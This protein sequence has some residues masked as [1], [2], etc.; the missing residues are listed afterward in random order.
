MRVSI[1]ML[2]DSTLLSKQLPPSTTFAEIAALVEADTGQPV[3]KIIFN[4]KL[5]DPL[6]TLATAGY[7]PVRSLVC[8]AL[9]INAQPPARGG[10]SPRVAPINIHEHVGGGGGDLEPVHSNLEEYAPVSGGATMRNMPT[11]CRPSFPHE[12]LPK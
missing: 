7:T 1:K 11:P 2:K 5:M 3:H 9:P 4:G 12:S 6:K 8:M 10:A